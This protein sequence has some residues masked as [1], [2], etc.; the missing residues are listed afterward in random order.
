MVPEFEVVTV[1]KGIWLVLQ[2]FN[3][4]YVADMVLENHVVGCCSNDYQL[5]QAGLKAQIIM[6]IFI[7]VAGIFTVTDVV[8]FSGP[9]II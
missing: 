5:H 6:G 2:S 4:L 7:Y 1:Y 9:I 8:I 3:I